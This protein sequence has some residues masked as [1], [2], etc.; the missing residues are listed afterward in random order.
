MTVITKVVCFFNFFEVQ[1]ICSVLDIQQSD[2]DICMYMY[3]LFRIFCFMIYHRILT[4]V[5]CVV[6]QDL[7]VHPLCL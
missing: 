5:P 4:I 7:V 2:S 3:M 6:Q 1:L